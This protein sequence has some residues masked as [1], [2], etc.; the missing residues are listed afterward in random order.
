MLIEKEN[1]IFLQSCISEGLIPLG[2]R[3][4]FNLAIDVNDSDLVQMIKKECDE[5]SSRLLDLIYRE[6]E[7]E[8]FISS[9]PLV[10]TTIILADVSDPEGLMKL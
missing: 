7:R 5:N 9:D 10:S 4:S 1:T 2:L 8:R 6:R 3:K